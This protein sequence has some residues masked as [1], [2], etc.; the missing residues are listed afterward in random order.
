MLAHFIECRVTLMQ[1]LVRL[2]QPLSD[3]R[4][5]LIRQFIRLRFNIGADGPVYDHL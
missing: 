1:V 5:L 2:G 4:W 3:G